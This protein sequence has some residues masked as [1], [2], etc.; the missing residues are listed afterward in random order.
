MAL[1]TLDD[2]I[3]SNIDKG[4]YFMGLFLD[5]SKAFDIVNHQILMNKHDKCGIMGVANT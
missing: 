2:T 4:R 3:I 1:S 5:F